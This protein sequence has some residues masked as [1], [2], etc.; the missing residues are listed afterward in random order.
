MESDTNSSSPSPSPPIPEHVDPLP[1][2]LFTITREDSKILSEYL[3]EFEE[4]DGDMRTKIVANAMAALVMHRPAGEPF[5]KGEASK[6]RSSH[7][8]LCVV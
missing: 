8:I 2:G 4:G 1:T 6:V 3:K 5:D 7:I